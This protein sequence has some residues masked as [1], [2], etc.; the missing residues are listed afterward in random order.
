MQIELYTIP[1]YL[2]ALYSIKDGTNREARDVIQTVVMEEMLHMALVANLLIAVDGQS[3]VN[4]RFHR[5]SRHL[6]D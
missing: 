5:D 4:G 3:K 2:C 6:P 1:P